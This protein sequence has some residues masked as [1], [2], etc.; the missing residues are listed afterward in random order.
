MTR[1]RVPGPEEQRALDWLHQQLQNPVNDDIVPRDTG[2]A[3][4]VPV[5]RIDNDEFGHMDD[6]EP[7]PMDDIINDLSQDPTGGRRRGREDNTNQGR[8]VVPRVDGMGDVTGRDPP[9]VL[10]AARAS[11]NAAPGPSKETPI[12]L[13]RPSY[14][15]QETHTTTCHW[16]GYASIVGVDHTT[17]C[18]FEFRLTCPQ[19]VVVTSMTALP[20]DGAA[21]TKG[22]HVAPY[23]NGNTRGA[24]TSEAFPSTMTSGTYTSEQANWF[25]YWAKIYEYYTV[26]DC[27]YHITIVN[28]NTSAGADIIVGESF[29]SYSDTAT[30]TGNVTPTDAKLHEAMQW[31]QMRWHILQAGTSAENKDNMKIISGHYKPG[32]TRRNIFN[33]GDVKTWTK[34]DGTMPTLKETLKLLFYKAPLAW[35]RQVVGTSGT[36]GCN[37]QIQVTYTVQFKDLKSQARYP[38]AGGTD[39]TQTIDTDTLQTPN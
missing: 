21:W 34:T 15:L 11:N 35:L 18:M 38:Y 31:K 10:E 26:T 28:N 17:P 16:A 2:G 3:R 36:Y 20:A 9:P 37:L 19:D 25:G 27:D 12:T 33:D 8:A 22:T 13:A 29:D 39:I 14:G 5:E 23:N 7:M 24:A 4:G 6:D 32:Q 1:R 30:A